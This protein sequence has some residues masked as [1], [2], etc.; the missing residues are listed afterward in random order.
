MAGP[1]A[2]TGAQPL[3]IDVLY[4]RL[5]DLGYTYGPA[6]QGVRAAWRDE[7]SVYTELALSDEHVEAGGAFG[8]HP[9]LLD[10]ALHGGLEGLA[11]G[12]ESV[13]QL[14]FSWSG[15]WL[16][17][18][19]RS[20][21]RVRITQVDGTGL[22]I[23]LADERGAAVGGVEQL[24]FRPAERAKFNGGRSTPHNSLFQ[25]DWTVLAATDQA[26]EG[27]MVVLGDLPVPVPRFADL[28]ALEDAVAAGEPARKR[29][30]SRY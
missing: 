16:A 29:S 27:R 15:V 14:P 3:D 21:V 17:Q 28:K 4:A 23:D 1:V 6:F 10:A 18:T 24:V 22:R 13:T 9:A 20:R 30:S 7:D 12:D 5:A 25:V 11:T 2:P 19:G 26:S 8:I